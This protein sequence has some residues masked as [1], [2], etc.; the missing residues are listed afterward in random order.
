VGGQ[1]SGK[2]TTKMTTGF[3]STPTVTFLVWKC[4]KSRYAMKSIQ[5]ILVL[6]IHVIYCLKLNGYVDSF[7]YIPHVVRIWTFLEWNEANGN[8]HFALPF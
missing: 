1:L 3:D 2:G 8:L 7:I 5:I 6:F 4:L